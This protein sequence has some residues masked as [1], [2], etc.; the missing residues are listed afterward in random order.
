MNVAFFPAAVANR[1]PRLA[2]WL[3][4]TVTWFVAH[5]LGRISPQ[6]ARRTLNRY[7]GWACVLLAAGAMAARGPR[8]GRPRPADGRRLTA[9]C[10]AGPILRRAL[11]RGTLAERAQAICAV[12][13]APDRWIA[14]IVRR[15]QRRFTKLG[16]LPRAP[17]A[18]GAPGCGALSPRRAI[19]S[20]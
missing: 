10:V 4:L 11:R 1:L 6:A 8:R 14:H 18:C 9:R 19:N 12:L 5:V 2:L 16:C 7:A 3:C 17:R 13:A 20:S 15:L